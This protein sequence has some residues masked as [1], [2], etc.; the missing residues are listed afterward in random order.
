MGSSSLA[1]QHT[2]TAPLGPKIGSI[3]EFGTEVVVVV[4]VD[5]LQV[6][7]ANS[8]TEPTMASSFAAKES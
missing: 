6:I 5:R 2:L 7:E 1:I 8:I 4:A 3:E